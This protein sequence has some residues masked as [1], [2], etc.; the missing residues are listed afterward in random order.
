[1]HANRFVTAISV[2]LLLALTAPA[3]RAGDKDFDLVAGHIKREYKAQKRE[4]LPFF[5]RVAVKM[6][7][8]A[9]VKSLKLTT[10]G[11][12]SGTDGSAGLES[13]LREKLDSSWVPLVR[14]YS[15]REREQV[16]VYVRPAKKDI[17]ILVVAIDRDEATVL[18][19]KLDPEAASEWI[20]GGGLLGRN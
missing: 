2:A 1:M 3:A 5:A 8:P 15:K 4:S 7:R 11:G 14:V 20:E 18:K 19:A 17:E 10:F 12:L 9:G 13:V 16:Y 6:A